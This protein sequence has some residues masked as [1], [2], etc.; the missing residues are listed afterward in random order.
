M[1]TRTLVI[2][3]IGLSRAAG[4]A[5]EYREF[6]TGIRGLG[7]GGA[8]V[9]AVNDETALIVNPAALGKLRNVYGTILDPEVDI[10]N[11]FYNL[12]QSKPFSQL[13]DLTEI[14]PVVQT[15]KNTYYHANAQLFPSLVAKNFGIGVFGKY[16]LDAR[17][18]ATGR[19]L[20]SYYRNDIAAVI[21][22]NLRLF[23]GR[24][25]IGA[26]AKWISRIEMT[27][28]SLD[29]N[30]NPNLTLASRGQEGA[31]LST[32]VGL[33]LTAPWKFLPTLT[34]VLRNVGGTNFE[35]ARG[36]RPLGNNNVAPT[37]EVQDL[38]VGIGLFPIHSTSSRSSFVLEYRGVMT[39]QNET[40]P[41]RRYHAGYEF[42]LYDIVFLRVGYNQKYWTAGLE[43]SSE[44]IQFQ[45]ATYGED[46][47]TGEDRRYVGK[48]AI[49]F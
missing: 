44:K 43:L 27:T 6:Y 47:P 11:Q 16:L 4:A 22:L 34:G 19:Y 30:T 29:L 37:A 33:I 10:T 49:R 3:L 41:T 42:N 13:F 35:Q 21:G 9:A 23:D 40:D 45:F 25:K 32:D 36:L 48:L 12:Y 7:M 20:T 2:I 15:T 18:D 28:T 5:E 38:D 39:A 26:N 31:G 8:Q 17:T 1:K 14:A 46:V 24:V